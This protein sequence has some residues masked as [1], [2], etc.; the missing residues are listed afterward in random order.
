MELQWRHFIN[1]HKILT[2]FVILTFMWYYNT[3]TFAAH[4]YLAMHSSYSYCWLL[5]DLWFRDRNFSQS[6]SLVDSVI[7]FTIMSTA[8]WC[9]PFVIC[10]SQHVPSNLAVLLSVSSF[11]FGML[12]HYGS[13]CQKH[14][15]LRIQKG[16]ITDGFF[17]TTRNP[18]YFGEILTYIGFLGISG[19]PIPF[20]MVGM[21]VLFLFYP[22][23][24]R[25]DE[26]MMR[27]EGYKEYKSRSSFLIPFIF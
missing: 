21:M 26:S 17:S 22:N 7:K 6:I 19:N 25:K 16:L 1:L 8:Y 4:L 18:N 20:A 14:F 23:M 13:D 12:F 9:A 15:T 11:G 5:K 2:P 3:Y 24:K 27:Y 10:R